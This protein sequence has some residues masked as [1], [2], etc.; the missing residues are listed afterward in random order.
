MSM[1]Y[2]RKELERVLRL[3]A[4][5]VMLDFLD[6]DK[7]AGRASGVKVSSIGESHFAGHFPGQ[8]VLPGVLQ[9]AGMVQVSQVLFNEMFPGEDDIVLLG[10]KRVKFRSPVMPGMM[11][12]VECELKGENEDGT[13]EFMV[14]NTCDDGKLASS[15]SVILGRRAGWHEPYDTT[16]SNPVSESVASAGSFLDSAAIMNILPHRYPFLF[17]DYIAKRDGDKVV[18]IK[19]VSAND[20]FFRGAPDDAAVPESLLCEMGAQAGCACVLSRPENAGKLGFFMAIDN[21]ESLAPIIPGDQ[22]AIHIELP[23]SKGRFGKGSGEIRV[24]GEVRFRLTLM[25]AIVDA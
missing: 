6:V 19:N 20:S 3:G 17:I 18:A 8:P 2:G 10:L 13:V 1:H 9:T 23:P 16:G 14:K 11:L 5:L 24:N 15:G 22:L 4:P 21:A 7:E 25:F 12:S